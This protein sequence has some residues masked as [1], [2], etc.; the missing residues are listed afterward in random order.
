MAPTISTARMPA[1]SPSATI[2]DRNLAGGEAFDW[3]YADP[4]A[5]AA[6]ARTDITDGLGKPWVFRQKDLWSFWSNA[7]YERVG[8]VELA[9]ADRLGAAKQ[10]DLADRTGLS[11]GRQGLEPAERV[12][13]S[14]IVGGRVFR[15]SPAAAATI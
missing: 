5:R 2:C 1:P 8:G 3:Y 6:Q 12:S 4:D 14:E 9:D 15:I 10:T 7:H 13:R 11:G